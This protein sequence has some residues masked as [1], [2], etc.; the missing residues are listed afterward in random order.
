MCFFRHLPGSGYHK[1]QKRPRRT[2]LASQIHAQDEEG[3]EE[4]KGWV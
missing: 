1:A 2:M 3:G 4:I